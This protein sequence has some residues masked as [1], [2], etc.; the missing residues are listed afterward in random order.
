MISIY[1]WQHLEAYLCPVLVRVV[2]LLLQYL[3][4][5][6]VRQVQATIL[7]LYSSMPAYLLSNQLLV[8][9]LM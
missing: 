2:K 5:E 3:S 9:T 8:K 4:L 7:Q 1:F 6:L